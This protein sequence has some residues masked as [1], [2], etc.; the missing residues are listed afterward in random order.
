ML[1]GNSVYLKC[2]VLSTQ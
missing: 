1:T 2:T